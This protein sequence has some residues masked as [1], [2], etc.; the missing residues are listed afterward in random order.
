MP[1][2]ALRIEDSLSNVEKGRI[3]EKAVIELFELMGF[4]PDTLLI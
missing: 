1:D 2:Y 4:H 3:F